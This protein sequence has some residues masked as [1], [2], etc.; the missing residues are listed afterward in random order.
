MS[1]SLLVTAFTLHQAGALAEARQTYDQLL[2]AEPEHAE[3]HYLMGMLHW[4]E[5]DLP[6]AMLFLEQAVNLKPDSIRYR[7]HFADLLR[8]LGEPAK[9]LPHYQYLIE[10]SPQNADFYNTLGSIF[11]ELGDFAQ[12]EVAYQKAIRLH[13]LHPEAV[14]N[15][16]N[17]WQERGDWRRAIHYYKQTIRIHPG[18]VEGHFNMGVVWQTQ[19]KF[20]RAVTCYERALE[21]SPDHFRGLSN[22]AQSLHRL[23]R[24]P[25]AAKRYQQAL[26]LQDHFVLNFN[27]A[28]VWQ[29][30]GDPV[31]AIAYYDKARTLAPDFPATYQLLI[32]LL[33]GQKHL[34]EAAKYLDLAHQHFSETEGWVQQLAQLIQQ[35]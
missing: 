6:R 5:Q 24:L 33:V 29:E 28:G 7:S 1:H 15:L 16:A 19:E 32:P 20:E 4:Q 25:E 21:L 2:L 35:A 23:G 34:D 17:L 14:Y 30:S 3:A 13:P 8:V 9:A 12:A 11:Q 31:A 27:L 10:E 26:A 18:H 22:L